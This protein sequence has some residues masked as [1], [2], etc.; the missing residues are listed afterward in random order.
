MLRRSSTSRRGSTADELLALLASPNVRSRRPVYERYDHLV[1]SRTVRRPGLDAAVLRLRPS[2]AGSPSRSTGRAARARSTRARPAPA[3]SS[4]PRA[5][6]PAR[7]G[8]RWPITDCLNFGNPEKPEIAWELAEAIEGMARAC[9]ALGIPVVSG[10]VSLYNETD[11]RAIPPTPVVGCVGLVADVR[12]VPGA[13]RDGDASSSPAATGARSTAPSTRRASWAGR[14][15][16]RRRPTTSP[17]RRSS[18]SSGARPPRLSAAHDVVRRRARASHSP[19]WRST[20]ALGADIDLDRD[21]LEWFG[22]GAG[23]AVVACA[24]ERRTSLEGV[25]LRRARAPSAATGSSGVAARRPSRAPTRETARLMCGVVGIHAPERDV[26]RLSYFGLFALQHRGQESAG[27]AVSDDGRLTV[28][29]DMGLVTQVFSEQKLRGLRGPDRD[30]PLPL[31][32]H[33]LDALDERAADRPARAA[34]HGRARPQRQPDEHG[35]A[36][37]GAHR[38]GACASRPPPTRR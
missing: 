16:G 20:P 7:A 26:A 18:T 15:V 35:G 23:R 36:P 1:G 14:P 10:N 37:R 21:A 6:S 29:R 34:A 33:R 5:T 38:H 28:L 8:A 11:G 32:D 4:R 22:E 3:P 31:L 13:W 9:E 27:I 17:R 30:R 19:S 12:A 25:P 2:L 24:P